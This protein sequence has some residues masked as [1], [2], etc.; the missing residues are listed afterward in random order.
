MNFFFFCRY[1][2]IVLSSALD[3]VA[4]REKKLEELK[5]SIIKQI[6]EVFDM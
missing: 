5:R 4:V 3:K 6:K 1:H 2:S